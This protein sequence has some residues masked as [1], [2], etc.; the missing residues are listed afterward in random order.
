M[1]RRIFPKPPAAP[2]PAT[3][4]FVITRPNGLFWFGVDKRELKRDL[5]ETPRNILDPLPRG[6]SHDN[7]PP[8]CQPCMVMCPLCFPHNTPI[9][10]NT[11][12]P[13]TSLN[14]PSSF[15]NQPATPF[16]SISLPEPTLQSKCK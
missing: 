4:S 12:F 8:Q 1:K 3:H 13:F 14:W 2:G 11:Y 5:G 6:L 10:I 9:V 7:A 15:S 16:K